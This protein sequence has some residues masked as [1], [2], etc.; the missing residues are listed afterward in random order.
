MMDGGQKMVAIIA[1]G[2]CALLAVVALSSNAKAEGH[3]HSD[4]TQLMASLTGE[5]GESL[6]ATGDSVVGQFTFYGEPFDLAAGGEASPDTRSS[7][8][9]LQIAGE[10]TQC[11]QTMGVNLRILPLPRSVY[12]NGF[13]STITMLR[14]QFTA[15]IVMVHP[16]TKDWH[17]VTIDY[18]GTPFQTQTIVVN[19]TNFT[20]LAEPD[21][22]PEEETT[23]W[24]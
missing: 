15:N 22:A 23:P 10:D 17:I 5:Y 1:L 2:I 8:V 7:S 16:E 3:C 12:P 21:P 20:L 19:G 9:L 14:D 11:I 13:E 18:I 24:N 6:L 4:P